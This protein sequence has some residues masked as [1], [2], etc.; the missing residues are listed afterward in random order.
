MRLSKENKSRKTETYGIVEAAVK[1]G[2]DTVYCRVGSSAVGRFFKGA[3]SVDNKVSRSYIFHLIRKAGGYFREKFRKTPKKVMGTEELGNTVGIYNED[4]IGR[5]VK[6]RF[7]RSVE[8][9]IIVRTIGRTVNGI[10]SLPVMSLGIFLL[11]LGISV[12][13]IQAVK[14][15]TAEAPVPVIITMGQGILILLSSLPALLN[16][17]ESIYDCVRSGLLGS[18]VMFSLMGAEKER[19]AL[20]GTKNYFGVAS[21]LLGVLSGALTLKYDVL[22][23]FLIYA[24]LICAVRI[25]YMPEF[26]IVCLLSVL[27]LVSLSPDPALAASLGVIYIAICFFGKAA[28]G[29]RSFS[30]KFGD[31]FVIMY[32]LVLVFTSAGRNAG[33]DTGREL[34]ITLSFILG[35]F[36]ACNLIVSVKWVKAC[37]NA[38]I[39][40]SYFAALI[41]VAQA[42]VHRRIYTDSVFGDQ[43]ACA[44]YIGVGCA[45]TLAKMLSLSCN[46]RIYFFLFIVQYAALVLSGS[47]LSVIIL[48]LCLLAFMIVRSRKT[49]GALLLGVLL[50]PL[51]SC[52][53]SAQDVGTFYELLTFRAP[54]Q[55]Y[56]VQV[57][58]VTVQMIS[59]NFVQGIGLGKETFSRL[60]EYYAH[61]STLQAHNSMSLALQMLVQSGI[62]GF[63]FFGGINIHHAVRCFTF[64]TKRESDPAVRVYSVGILYAFAYMFLLGVF[65]NVWLSPLNHLLFW[66]LLGLSSSCNEI[67][68]QSS[69]K[70]YDYLEENSTDIS[71]A[72]G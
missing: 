2:S 68:R 1:K 30:F 40:S 23:I 41:S 64:Y 39:A 8:S 52:F 11:A 38:F 48:T 63:V 42:I 69:E 56:K 24:V 51:I 37:V 6:K 72:F 22:F 45:V 55:E 43:M 9:S 32:A 35:Y 54:S 70:E 50:I 20:S 36:V 26:G 47:R 5:S 17:E 58:R 25:I 60:F 44:V 67:A 10:I 14:L 65:A 61:G 66:L 53:V 59:D 3:D 62:V 31:F 13:A 29:K 7:R 18:F 71:I 15:F 46:K 19:P 57:W 28:V 16:R 21:F 27:P 49:V 4:T 33:S 12:T 34:L